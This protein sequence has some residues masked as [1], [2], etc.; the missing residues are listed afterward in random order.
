MLLERVDSFIELLPPRQQE[1]LI[2]RKKEDLAVK[3]I[4]HQLNISPK[5]VE[6]HLTEA[7][8]K[9]RKGLGENNIESMFL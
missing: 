7:L 3:E 8:K 5:T 6:N 2:K 9:I 4:A 1:I